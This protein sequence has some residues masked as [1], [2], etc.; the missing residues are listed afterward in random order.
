MLVFF[1]DCTLHEESINITIQQF[2]SSIKLIFLVL[3]TRLNR[4][5]FH[6]HVSIKNG[7]DKNR[8][9]T[10]H[11][12]VS[13][14]ISWRNLSHKTPF[15]LDNSNSIKKVNQRAK[16]LTKLNL[17]SRKMFKVIA[18]KPSLEVVF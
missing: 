16:L 2:T 12:P 10:T 14:S 4:L 11:D 18:R 7:G 8:M 9:F 5:E 15:P 13:F 1:R 6:Q 3:I 17:F